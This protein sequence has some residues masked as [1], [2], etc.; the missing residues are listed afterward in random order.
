M[1]FLATDSLFDSKKTEKYILS[2]QVCLDGFS[3]SV[4]DDTKARLL[5]CGMV[6]A[7]ISSEKFLGRR[8][9][10]WVESEELLKKP[11]GTTN[12]LFCSRKITLIPSV[13]YEFERQKQIFEQNYGTQEDHAIRDNY[14]PDIKANLVFAVPKSLIET[15][16]KLFPGC[17]VTHSIGLLHKKIQE[18][19]YLGNYKQLISLFF[20]K[21]S[22]SLL[23]YKDGQFIQHNSFDYQHQNDVAFYVLSVLKT[24]KINSDGLK[25]VLAGNVTQNGDVHAILSGY[26]EETEFLTPSVQFNKDVFKEPLHLFTP[27]V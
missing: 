27:L 15:V 14:L 19:Q 17:P 18:S 23:L 12:I 8:F 9:K 2:I 1:V 16:D 21:S 25:V 7:T 13:F 26:F 4:T 5:A 3:F 22:F 24:M 11:F 20:Q 6:P 10:E